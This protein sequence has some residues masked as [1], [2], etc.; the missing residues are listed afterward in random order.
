MKLKVIFNLLLLVL[1]LSGCSLIRDNRIKLADNCSLSLTNLAVNE[2]RYQYFIVVDGSNGIER[3]LLTLEYSKSEVAIVASSQIG[4]ALFILKSN[5]QGLELTPSKLPVRYSPDQ[6]ISLFYLAL[7]LS[8]LK[9][10]CANLT[11]KETQGE[12][13][14]QIKNNLIYTI[15]Q[16]FDSL[17]ITSHKDGLVFEVRKLKAE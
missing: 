9:D 17:K 15:K 10:I 2:G 13:I 5:N 1:L 14:I 8:N 11:V 16:E 4:Y 12:T 3:V 7:N 6:I